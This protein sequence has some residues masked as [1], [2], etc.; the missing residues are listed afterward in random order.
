MIVSMGLDARVVSIL[1]QNNTKK[2][3]RFQIFGLVWNCHIEAIYLD[4]FCYMLL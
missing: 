3:V 2:S 4:V 1:G